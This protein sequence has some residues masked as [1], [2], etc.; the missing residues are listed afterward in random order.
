M[1]PSLVEYPYI[2]KFCDIYI[3]L[4]GKTICVHG[5]NVLCPVQN[6]NGSLLYLKNF[7]RFVS[8]FWV[9]LLYSVLNSLHS[10]FCLFILLKLFFSRSPVTF[11]LLNWIVNSQISSFLTHQYPLIQLITA[12]SLKVFSVELWDTIFF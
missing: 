5:S 9:S 11:I 3:M 1:C 2:L 6:L 12:S 10:G 8:V 7:E 4:F